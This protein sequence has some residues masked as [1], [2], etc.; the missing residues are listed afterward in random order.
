MFK[1]S[2]DDYW[3]GYEQGQKNAHHP[4]HVAGGSSQGINEAFGCLFSEDL[5]CFRW[6]WTL[7]LESIIS[8]LTEQEE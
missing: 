4:S 3:S 7:A 2:D 5:L 1:S 8:S 6:N